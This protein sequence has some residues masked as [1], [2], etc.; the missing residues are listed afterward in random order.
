MGLMVQ[1]LQDVPEEQIDQQP[2]FDFFQWAKAF[3]AGCRFGSHYNLEGGES[4]I[5]DFGLL[6]QELDDYFLEY[7]PG[8]IFDDF[9]DDQP[10]DIREW[11]QNQID[12]KRILAWVSY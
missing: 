2:L 5:V 9:G 11:L 7:E 4:A 12:Q 10:P 6:K 3:D 8:D 1:T